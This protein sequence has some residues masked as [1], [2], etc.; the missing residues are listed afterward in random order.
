MT[1]ITDRKCQQERTELES[2]SD[3]NWT[4]RSKI[5]NRYQPQRL[6]WSRA[7]TVNSA[8]L[9]DLHKRNSDPFDHHH[10]FLQYHQNTITILITANSACPWVMELSQMLKLKVLQIL[11]QSKAGVGFLWFTGHIEHTHTNKCTQYECKNFAFH[12]TRN[13]VF[14]GLQIP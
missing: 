5:S 13:L 12:C 2:S 3:Q 4:E 7:M 8:W 11:I 1:Y 9:A 14:M 6:V 10:Q